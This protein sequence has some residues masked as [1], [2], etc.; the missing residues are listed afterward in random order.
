MLR[1]FDRT[2]LKSTQNPVASDVL[3]HISRLA[4][5]S[6]K[7]PVEL[8]LNAKT[9]ILACLWAEEIF[10]RSRCGFLAT[11]DAIFRRFAA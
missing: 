6:R 9:N 7:A 2:L 3:A 11:I 8:F 10:V 4:A 1:V 5:L